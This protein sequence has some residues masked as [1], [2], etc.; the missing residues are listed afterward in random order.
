MERRIRAREDWFIS[1]KVLSVQ[2]SYCAD[3][4]PIAIFPLLCSIDS[5]VLRVVPIDIIDINHNPNR[6]SGED[7]SICKEG[8]EPTACPRSAI[9]SRG[10]V[11]YCDKMFEKSQDGRSCK[12]SDAVKEE[13]DVVAGTLRCLKRIFFN[14]ITVTC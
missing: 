11:L 13:A 2:V 9:C 10:Y 12:V 8:T 3:M 1:R 7:R 6:C 5:F 4:P 14:G